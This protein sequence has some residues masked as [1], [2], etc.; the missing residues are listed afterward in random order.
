MA[1]GGVFA[2]GGLRHPAVGTGRGI[3]LGQAGNAVDIAQASRNHIG[4]M[5]FFRTGTGGQGIAA[6]ITEGSG[7]GQRPDPEGVQ[8]D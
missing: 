8:Y 4:D 6:C 5:E 7:I 2:H 3:G 1:D